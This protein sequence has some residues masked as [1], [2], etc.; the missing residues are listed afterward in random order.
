MEEA[1]IEV[2]NMGRM[3]GMGIL[4]I[5]IAVAAVWLLGTIPCRFPKDE[6]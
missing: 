1:T 3:W 4:L 2:L 6:P 5:A